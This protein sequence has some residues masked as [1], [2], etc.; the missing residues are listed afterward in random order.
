MLG[1]RF[2]RSPDVKRLAMVS[3]GRSGR[4]GRRTS[5]ST[6]RAGEP[7]TACRDVL[8]GR[9]R[10]EEFGDPSG[11]VKEVRRT[12]ALDPSAG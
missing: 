9:D 4:L 5:G 3:R 6:V 1:W 7:I 10:A 12:S 11:D 2:R 8:G